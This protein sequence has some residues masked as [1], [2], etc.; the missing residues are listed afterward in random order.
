MTNQHL[1]ALNS[2]TKYP[3]IP[4]YHGMGERG[5][6]TEKRVPLAGKVVIREKI[7]G[8]NAR[9]VFAPRPGYII[10]SREGLLHGRGD[11]IWN[12]DMGIVDAIRG[13][14]EQMFQRAADLTLNKK[15]LIVFFGEVYGGDIGRSAK[16]Y[17]GYGATG[18]RLFDVAWVPDWTEM[19]AWEPEKIASWRD[20][21][22]QQFLGESELR[23]YAEL[24]NLS[25]C[26]LVA[27]DDA[28]NL[29]TGHHETLEWL[30]RILGRSLAGL[31]ARAALRPEGVVV[32]TTDRKT[33]VKI[34][35][36]DYERTLKAAGA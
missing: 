34:R 29:P 24:Y 8:T 9:I 31:D 33:I 27:E 21:G 14:A 13:L 6:L 20:H 23:R 26:P 22:G 32:R 3:S 17:T 2:M 16:Q 15:G 7:D 1:Q 19:L 5:R 36:E 35:H 11:L 10:G 30:R 4:T 28:A 18:F 12:P 25:L